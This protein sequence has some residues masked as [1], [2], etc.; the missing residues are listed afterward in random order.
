MRPLS[1]L[2]SILAGLLLALPLPAA[3]AAIS[4]SQY[5]AQLQAIQKV[6]EVEKP[7]DGQL[8]QLVGPLVETWVV[9]TDN[10]TF[11]VPMRPI[12]AEISR[13]RIDN[14]DTQSLTDARRAVSLLLANA[15]SMAAGQADQ[16]ERARLDQILSRSEFSQDAGD[17]WWDRLK[18]KAKELLLAL[19]GKMLSSSSFPIV[20]RIVIWVVVG[21]ATVLIAFWVIRNYFK[22]GTYTT[23][24][25]IPGAISEKPWRDWQAEA[26][27]AAEQGCWRE[28]VHLSYWA[29]ISFLEG[30]GLWRPDRARTPREYLRLLPPNDD[31]RGALA[32]LTRG[33]ETVWYGNE[34]ATEREFAAT[35]VLLERLGCH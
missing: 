9:Q 7:D 6:L 14:R 35:T 29:G 8:Q 33:F 3:P 16:G 2:I 17:T 24:A 13:Y 27:A 5:I 22:E 19:L 28:A 12:L 4:L 20:G 34:Q 18:Q 32:E 23:L 1:L 11:N 25:G 15:T 26:K 21:T 31:H 10:H 30:Q